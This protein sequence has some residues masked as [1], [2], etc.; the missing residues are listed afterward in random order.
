M[1]LGNRLFPYPVLKSE[2]HQDYEKSYF[3]IDF[4]KENVEFDDKIIFKNIQF[5]T[6]NDNFRNNVTLGLIDVYVNLECSNTIFRK[7]IKLGIEPLDYEIKKSELSGQLMI[8]SFAVA[9]EEI[10]NYF[11]DDFSL[12][13]NHTRFSIDKYDI[14]AF[15]DGY[16][17]DIIHYV[18][19]DDKISSIFI[20]IP[21][22]DDEKDGIEFDYQGMKIH[23]KVPQLTYNQYDRLKFIPRHQ[24]LFFSMLAVPILAMSLRELQKENFDDL[25]I[26]YKWFISIKEVYLKIFNEELNKVD[27]ENL[28]VYKFSQT[29]FDNTL[30]KFIDDVYNDTGV[31]GEDQDE[32]D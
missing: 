23:I 19:K 9:K 20:V 13:Y 28:D 26:N 7:T 29:I 17:I 8:T 21:K 22:I 32:E 27:F 16:S 24:N 1:Q 18:Q 3:R 25:E 14:L 2:P 30:V 31:Y 4:E 6:N 12:D 5:L 15:D 11:D 10:K